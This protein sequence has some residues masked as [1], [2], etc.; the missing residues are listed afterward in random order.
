MSWRRS[1]IDPE[2]FRQE[3]SRLAHVWTFLGVTSDL[4]RD[5]D[6][7]TASIATRSVF[8]QRFGAELHGFENL[9]AH[10][11]YPLRH[12]DRGHG[13]VVCGYHH[14]QYDKEGRA[15]GI[16]YCRE[17]FDAHPQE[18]GARLG[19]IELATCGTMVF[20]RF[21]GPG[22]TETLEAFLGEGFG[23]LR[24]MSQMKR[25][26]R[27]LSLTIEANWRLC[28]HIT[29]D[30]YHA[31]AVHPT[32]LGKGGYVRRKDLGYFR[33]GLH[34]AFLH[35]PEAEAFDRMAA[36]CAAGTFEP[37]YYSI[38]QLLPNLLVVMVHSDA[39]FWSCLIQVYD[40]VR[41]DRTRMRAWLYPA[42]FAV[43]HGWWRALTEPVRRPI[44][45]AYAMRVFREDALICERLQNVAHQLAEPRLGKLEE[46][47]DWFEEAYRRLMAE[48]EAATV[49]LEGKQCFGSADDATT[50]GRAG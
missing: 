3:Q 34:S 19:R 47:I 14:W 38:F 6:W 8:V 24:A 7:F 35:T 5:G 17:L 40:P 45:S 42:P 10:R 39:G 33:F 20:G 36:D 15:V 16:P 50:S 4:T 32:S 22:A 43:R 9:C 27:H 29:L 41:H 48:E 12:C 13:P 26:A 49:P 25:P 2:A 44:V 37:R 21:P 46:R 11:G 28:M 23:I 18:L 31:P 1:I 30:D